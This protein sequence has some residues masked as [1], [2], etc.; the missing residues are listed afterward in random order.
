MATKSKSYGWIPFWSHINF[1][2]WAAQLCGI[3]REALQLSTFD[4]VVK[5]YPPSLPQALA[6]ET[7]ETWISESQTLPSG[8]K[9]RICVAVPSQSPNAAGLG[10]PPGT[11][12]TPSSKAPGSPQRNCCSPALP[13]WVGPELIQ[14]KVQAAIALVAWHRDNSLTHFLRGPRAGGSFPPAGS[15]GCNWDVLPPPSLLLWW[16]DHTGT[17]WSCTALPV[18]LLLARSAKTPFCFNL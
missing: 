16:W 12:D 18:Q 8:K 6:E 3:S 11:G 4:S 14:V 5:R 2:N 7:L 10:V 17:H 1:S 15:A 13:S 9:R